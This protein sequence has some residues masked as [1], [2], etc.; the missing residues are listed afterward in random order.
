MKAHLVDAEY[1]G[2]Q[3]EEGLGCS[4]VLV[5]G[6]HQARVY[7]VNTSG[8]MIPQVYFSMIKLLEDLRVMIMLLRSCQQAR[9]LLR[10]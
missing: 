1:Q 9:F 10:A 6:A 3:N 7:T 8:P 5:I 4:K 2:V